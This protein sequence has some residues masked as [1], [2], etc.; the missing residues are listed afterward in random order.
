MF[1]NDIIVGG[2]EQRFSFINATI[3]FSS[4]SPLA[5]RSEQACSQF[6]GLARDYQAQVIA[7]GEIDLPN[8]RLSAGN[9]PFGCGAGRE[10]PDSFGL[11]LGLIRHGLGGGIDEFITDPKLESKGK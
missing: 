10:R 9:L 4:T 8:M 5:L 2:A 3:S 6:N 7:C 1:K 11:L